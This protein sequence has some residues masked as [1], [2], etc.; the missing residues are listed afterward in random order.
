[1]C[2]TTGAHGNQ[3]LKHVLKYKCCT[4]LLPSIT[5]PGRATILIGELTL[6]LTGPGIVNPNDL[7][8]GKLAPTLGK[9]D[10]TLTMGVGEVAPPL[11]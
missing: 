7:G 4:D 2:V 9:A 10:L 8:T 1:M 6:A 5:R 11:T 3:V